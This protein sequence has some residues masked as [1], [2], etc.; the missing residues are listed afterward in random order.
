MRKLGFGEKWIKLVMDCVTSVTYSALVNGQ[1]SSIIKP[2]RGIRQGD[3]ISPY[4][5]IL[6]AE[7]LSSLVD[8]A[9]RN[10]EIKGVAITRGGI[11][12]N[13]LLFAD[14]SVIYGRAK[15]TEWY[16]IQ[17]LLGTYERA[18]GQCLNR[19]KTTIFF[20]SNTPMAVRRQIQ[21]VAGVAVCGNFEKYLGLPSIVG[22]S[23]YNAFKHLKERVWLKVNN[24]KNK[25]LSQAG[26]EVLL[27][28][29]VQAIPT[30]SMS[31]FLLP[32]K[33]C[34]EITAVMARFW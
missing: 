13:H 28:A 18:S 34:K 5:F 12:V 24:W 4:L 2:S 27:K 23:R 14:D 33:L 9:E 17:K 21:E 20:S 19:Q 31:V 15:L 3:P 26:K 8:M 25:F 1:Q 10:G 29:V 7:G 11:R 30:Y 16:K 22:R 6:C 32:R